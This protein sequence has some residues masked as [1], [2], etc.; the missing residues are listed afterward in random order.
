MSD[1]EAAAQNTD[2]ANG[3]KELSAELTTELPAQNSEPVQAIKRPDEQSAQDTANAGEA[4]L[5]ASMEVPKVPTEISISI[6]TH[7]YFISGIRD[8]VLNLTKSMTGF[9]EQWAYRFQAVVDELCNNA[10]EHGS[11][12]GDT[13]YISLISTPDES[14][15]VLV[16]DSGSGDEKT[17]AQA[18]KKLL[19]DRAQIVQGGQY[20]GFRGRGLPL[21]VKAWTDEMSFEDVEGGG[22][23]VKVK[24]YLRKEEDLV[25]SKQD[26]DPT[27]LILK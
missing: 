23:R 17:S 4:E 26:K 15:E 14:L 1:T 18:M 22:L 2:Q 10:I 12:P 11:K 7:A 21:I 6:P 5:A 19:E 20:M 9:S 25:S 8:F 24:K 16:Q 3:L 13:I 27:H